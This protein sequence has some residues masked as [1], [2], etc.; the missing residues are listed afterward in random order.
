M[1]VNEVRA[2][3]HELRKATAKLCQFIVKWRTTHRFLCVVYLN[4]YVSIFQN[5]RQTA[6]IVKDNTGY[7]HRVNRASKPELS[8]HNVTRIK[9]FHCC[10]FQNF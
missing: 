4:L 8:M 1:L 5:N 6:I 10:I 7:S 9:I 2:L 3:V